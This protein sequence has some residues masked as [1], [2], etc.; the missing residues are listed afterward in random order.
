[1]SDYTRAEVC[2]V[3]CADLFAEDGEIL[4]SPMGTMPLIGARLARLTS[5]PDLLISDGAAYLPAETPALGASSPLEGW[6]PYRKVFDTVA[7]GTRHVVMGANQI[8]RFGN[9]NISC[10]G[11]HER[12]ARQMFGARGA[13]GNSVNHRTSYWVAKHA[14]R[15]FVESVDFASGVGYDRAIGAAARFHDIHRVV[16][17]LAVLDFA[18]PDR[19][20]RIASLHP[21]VTVEQVQQETG[22]PLIVPADVPLTREPTG[23]ELKLLR[24]V[25]DPKDIRSKEVPA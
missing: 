24:E 20:M 18:T 17:N 15:V 4:A 6:L 23:E 1:M 8:D 25:L 9:Q 16:T 21:G 14:A 10:L 5:N 7:A 12:P 13:P 19:V 3:A 2:A 11:P 22:F